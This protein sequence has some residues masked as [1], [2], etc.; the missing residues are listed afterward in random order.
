MVYELLGSRESQCHHCHQ[1]CLCL[2]SRSCFPSSALL[3]NPQPDHHG[4]TL[5]QILHFPPKILPVLYRGLQAPL[6]TS[7]HFGLLWEMLSVSN[8]RQS[9]KE[10]W[11]LRISLMKPL[12][13]MNPMPEA[14][15]L[16]VLLEGSTANQ[17]Q[18]RMIATPL[19][20]FSLPLLT[21]HSNLKEMGAAGLDCALSFPLHS[22]G[23]ILPD[24]VYLPL[25]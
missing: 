8:A 18:R 12:S 21:T 4:A 10:L 11:V 23:Q 7:P 16:N 24:S 6:L 14:C 9:P 20:S 19:S 2:S 3:V 15:E 17:W 13:W 1:L 22:S 25:L 5:H